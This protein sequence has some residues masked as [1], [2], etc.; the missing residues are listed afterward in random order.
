M[1]IFA[2]LF[3]NEEKLVNIAHVIQIVQQYLKSYSFNEG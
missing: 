2:S 1:P 3:Q